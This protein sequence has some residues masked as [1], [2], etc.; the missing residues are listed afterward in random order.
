MTLMIVQDSRGNMI[1]TISVYVSA[2]VPAVK[3]AA[4]YKS[5]FNSWGFKAIGSWIE[6]KNVGYKHWKSE[7]AKRKHL[8]KY[9]RKDLS[10]V[11]D[12][13]IFFQLS[14][15]GSS[16]GMYGELGYAIAVVI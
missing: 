1:P 11:E 15:A 9:A 3:L 4:V 5:K 8:T 14:L 7:S 6:D 13:D 10:E 2:P 12:A 16:G